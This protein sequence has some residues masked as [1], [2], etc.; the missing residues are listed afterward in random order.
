MSCRDLVGDEKDCVLKEGRCSFC[1]S[2]EFFGGP[3]GGMS[4]NF[5]CCG[6]GARFNISPFSVQVI[7]EP[8]HEGCLHARDEREDCWLDR[9]MGGSRGVLGK[10]GV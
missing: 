9:V 3:E 4:K 5:V 10:L 2:Q 6:C 1:G 8:M 7:G